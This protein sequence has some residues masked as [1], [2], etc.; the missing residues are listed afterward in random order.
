MLFFIS[1]LL[2]VIPFMVSFSLI[3]H[4]RVSASNMNRSGDNGQPCL[5]PLS[6]RNHLD[7]W[8]LFSTVA[9]I[10]WYIVLTYDL[11]LGPKLNA[12]KHLAKKF[13]LTESK[14]FSKSTDSSIPLIL[15]LCVYIMISSI[16]LML[17][18]MNIF[19]TYPVWSSS[20][21]WGKNF[22]NLL[23]KAFAKIL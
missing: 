13:K 22:I 20:I 1:Q 15:F 17:F 11:N 10:S 6:K 14:A 4:D 18:S 2:I 7:V 19:L 9:D 8:P 12:S 16:I 23:A 21:S 3:L 5:T